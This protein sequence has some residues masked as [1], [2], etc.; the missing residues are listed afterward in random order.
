MPDGRENANLVQGVLLLFECQVVY[1]DFLHRVFLA[2]SKPLD[3]VDARIG[4][5]P[6][7]GYELQMMYLV[8]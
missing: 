7:G 8:S 3:L 1:V 2:V 4:A 5:R 6:C